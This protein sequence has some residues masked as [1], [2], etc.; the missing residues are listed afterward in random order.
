MCSNLF[1]LLFLVTSCIVLAVPHCM[2]GILIK[3][4][5]KKTLFWRSSSQ[6]DG[7]TGFISSD[8]WGWYWGLLTA[9]L[10]NTTI[11]SVSEQLQVLL[12]VSSELRISYRLWKSL[13]RLVTSDRLEGMSSTLISLSINSSFEKFYSWLL[14][15]TI[16][17]YEYRW[18]KI[19]KELGW[20]KFKF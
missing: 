2:E 14:V 3:K 12:T 6:I 19:K 4:K 5:K 7:G 11:L 1:V 10:C 15:Q 20:I 16:I 17:I 13:K 18:Y 9:F 8:S